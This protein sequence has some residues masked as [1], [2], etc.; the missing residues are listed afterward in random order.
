VSGGLAGALDAQLL[1]SLVEVAVSLD[2]LSDYTDV[3]G[4]ERMDRLPA[5]YPHLVAFPLAMKLMTAR[6]ASSTYQLA[7]TM[8]SSRPT[9]AGST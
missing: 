6:M 3:C 1:D 8:S 5:T 9:A 2:E 7:I 4:F